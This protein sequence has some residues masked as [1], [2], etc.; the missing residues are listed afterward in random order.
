MQLLP[1]GTGGAD[2]EE[3]PRD[4]LR[5]GRVYTV[6]MAGGKMAPA[7]ITEIDGRQFMER[8][9]DSQLTIM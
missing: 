5:P 6:Q 1:V 7:G 4:L 9:L 2:V 8:G 3:L